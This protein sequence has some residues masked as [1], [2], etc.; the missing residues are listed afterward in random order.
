MRPR[1]GA[2]FF[3]PALLIASNLG[4]V[5]NGEA[6]SRARTSLLGPTGL[7]VAQL[8]IAGPLNV[9]SPD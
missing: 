9:R 7:S 8:T 5:D 3:G 4:L 1:F 2:G 6:C